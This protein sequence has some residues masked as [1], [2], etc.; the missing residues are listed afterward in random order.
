MMAGND[1]LNIRTKPAILVVD[2]ED[3]V[4]RSLARS[5]R[6]QFTVFTAT[7]A[8]EALDIIEREDIAVVLADQRMPGL[9]G[10]ELLE[11]VKHIRPESIG[12]IISGYTDITALIDAINLGTVRGYLPKPWDI[13]EL[14]QRLEKA[15][16]TYQASFLNRDMLRKSSE[17]VTRMQE[18][19]EDLRKA[20]N[21]LATGDVS[22]TLSAWDE[23]AVESA[24]E[25]ASPDQAVE[26]EAG[27]DSEP[28]EASQMTF[29][30]FHEF[31]QQYEDLIQQA[32]L[33]RAY[34]VEHNVSEQL[35]EMS[36]RM[37]DLCVSPRD[38]VKVHSTALKLQLRDA[39]SA[40]VQALVEESRLLLMELM[41]YLIT[42]YRS[43][44]LASQAPRS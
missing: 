27:A 22:K 36:M 31:V 34:K 37:G 4:T 8:R 5:L 24:T 23:Q 1:D 38:L 21:Q 40:R 11:Q 29:E 12:V 9:T 16:R 26:A 18:E 17:V 41:G 20:I 14:R 25:Y 30:T 6:D 44:F 7:S 19:V 39:T 43:R 42:Y 28:I 35:R 15:A 33:N 10:V 3:K 2:D 32:M 13:S